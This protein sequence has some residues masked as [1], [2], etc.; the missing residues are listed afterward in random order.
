MGE[1][2]IR[3]YEYGLA[4]ASGAVIRARRA[5]CRLTAEGGKPPCHHR[6]NTVISPCKHREN[7]VFSRSKPW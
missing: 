3:I 1:N 2:R 4:G 7:A 5:R 6:E